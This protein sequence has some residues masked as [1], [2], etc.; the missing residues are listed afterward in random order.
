MDGTNGTFFGAV[1]EPAR[2][3][4]ESSWRGAC[5]VLEWSLQGIFRILQV[6]FEI[7]FTLLEVFYRF[8]G[9]GQSSDNFMFLQV[10]SRFFR[11]LQAFSGFQVQIYRSLRAQ[12][13]KCIRF[14]VF[15]ENLKKSGKT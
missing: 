14:Q 7:C 2:S 4:N 6:L 12:Q 3:G 13:R 9:S 8:L 11:L 15:S 5:K 10:N 1:G